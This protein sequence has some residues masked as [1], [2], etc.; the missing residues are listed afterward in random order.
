MYIHKCKSDI[1][2]DLYPRVETLQAWH[3]CTM[4]ADNDESVFL[5]ENNV[6]ELAHKRKVCAI[7][8][9]IRSDKSMLISLRFTKTGSSRKLEEIY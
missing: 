5:S 8:V 4:A 7:L 9:E 3:G 6:S 1:K 2:K